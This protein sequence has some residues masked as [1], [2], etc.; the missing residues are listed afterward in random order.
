MIGQEMVRPDRQV[1]HQSIPF[2]V[3][4]LLIVG[5]FAIPLIWVNRKIVLWAKAAST[6][7]ILLLTWLLFQTSGYLVD[8]LDQRLAE[9]Q[10][11]RDQF[12]TPKAS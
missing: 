3:I 2:L 1:W 5:P 6:L 11:L 4:A 10:Y 12:L 8:T 9:I 7:G